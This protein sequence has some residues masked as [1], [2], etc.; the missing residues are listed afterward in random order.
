M[1]VRLVAAPDLAIVGL[2]GGVD[3]TVL[4]AIAGVGKSSIA[5]L[6]ITFERFLT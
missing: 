6:K 1:G 2:V 5:A 4:L 3:V